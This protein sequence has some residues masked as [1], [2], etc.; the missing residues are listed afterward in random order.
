VA[1]VRSGH[2]FADLESRRSFSFS[3]TQSRVCE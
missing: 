2:G 3:L 1:G